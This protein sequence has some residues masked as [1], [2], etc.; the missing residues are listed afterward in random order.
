MDTKSRRLRGSHVV[1]AFLVLAAIGT[2]GGWLALRQHPKPTVIVDVLNLDGERAVVVRAVQDTR[3]RSFISLFERERGERWGALIPGYAG[4]GARGAV[5]ATADVVFVRGSSSGQAAFFAFSGQTGQKLGRIEP[6]LGVHESSDTGFVLPRAPSL[7]DRGQVF[8][9]LGVPGQWLSVLAFS[10]HDG[11]L[12][13]RTDLDPGAVEQSVRVWLSPRQLVVQTAAQVSVLERATG[14]ISARIAAT[15]PAC[16]LDDNVYAGPI[17]GAERLVGL[18]GRTDSHTLFAVR[19]HQAAVIAFDDAGGIAWRLP[20]PGAPGQ[21]EGDVD[22][23]LDAVA[24]VTPASAPFAGRLTRFVP[25]LASGP[26]KAGGAGSD[27]LL[28]IDTRSG[29]F[30]LASQPSPWL[31]DARLMNADGR[32]YLYLPARRILAVL[33]GDT[34]QFG[35]VRV[36]DG[37]SDIWPR[38]IAGGRIWITRGQDWAVLDALTLEPVPSAGVAQLDGS[39]GGARDALF[40]ELG[41]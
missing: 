25:V 3:V 1:I 27:R 4:A 41:I 19:D 5:A 12:T 23:R 36:L 8:E 2:V 18:C 40:A 13:W 6:F 32:H 7:F 10:V 17:T 14:D 16:V 26:G 33:D 39:D 31:D 37:W 30:A 15:E 28:V 35:R 9:V 11:T 34:G 38:H 24:L 29:R 20:L 21:G 22:F